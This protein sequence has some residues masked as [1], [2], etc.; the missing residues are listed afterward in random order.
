MQDSREDKNNVCARA[1]KS[2]MDDSQYYEIKQFK[3]LKSA[4]FGTVELYNMSK[5]MVA[6]IAVIRSDNA[7]GNELTYSSVMAAVK[8]VSLTS[9]DDDERYLLTLLYNGT[10]QEFVTA[11]GVELERQYNSSEGPVTSTIDEGDLIRIATNAN[12]EIVDYHK[13]I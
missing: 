5:D 9:V 3:D 8:N 6:G 4:T 12:N 1:S 13:N 2:L 11:E 7:G 10:E